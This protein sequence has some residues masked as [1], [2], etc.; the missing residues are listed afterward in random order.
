MGGFGTWPIT[1]QNLIGINLGSISVYCDAGV[2]FAI[3]IDRGQNYQGSSRNMRKGTELLPYL[4]WSDAA[5][6]QEWGDSGLST[7]DPNYLETHPGSLVQGTYTGNPLTFTL[8]GDAEVLDHS[9]GVFSDTVTI[10]I[11]W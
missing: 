10:T 2:D 5:G 4:L 7:I 11:A 8:W 9:P 6:T 1:E 3:G